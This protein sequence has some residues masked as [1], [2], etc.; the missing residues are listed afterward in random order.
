MRCIET[1]R[2]TAVLLGQAGLAKSL[3]HPLGRFP[4]ETTHAK[5][6]TDSE[7][8]SQ[9]EH[10]FGLPL[11]IVDLQVAGSIF[12]GE[13][14]V[15]RDHERGKD[16]ETTEQRRESQDPLCRVSDLAL[17]GADAAQAETNTRTKSQSSPT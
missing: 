12:V 6:S 9:I 14:G 2:R 15:S 1:P 7:D 11:R 17:A 13:R 16:L 10:F 5:V 3:C 8:W 4:A